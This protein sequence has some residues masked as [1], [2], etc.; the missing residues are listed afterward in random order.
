VL[1]VLPLY[2]RYTG[3]DPVKAA[4]PAAYDFEAL[5]NLRRLALAEQVPV[6]KQLELVLAELAAE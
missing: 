2:A 3:F 5:E 1:E 6:P 4:A